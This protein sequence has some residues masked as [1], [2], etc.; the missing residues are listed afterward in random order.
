MLLNGDVMREFD[1]SG[2]KYLRVL[3]RADIMGK[4]M[5]EKVR[6]VD[7]RRVTLLAQSKLFGVI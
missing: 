4:Q 7:F 1:E 5:K 2:F 6:K 3:E